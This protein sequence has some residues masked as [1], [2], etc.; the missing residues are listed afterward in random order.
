MFKNSNPFILIRRLIL[1]INRFILRAKHRRIYIF[2]HLFHNLKYLY[3]KNL[4]IQ[5]FNLYSDYASY[6]DIFQL[7]LNVH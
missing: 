3:G 5:N 2:I 1:T 6:L 7:D 4:I